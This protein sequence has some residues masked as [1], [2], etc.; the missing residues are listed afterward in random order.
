MS[1]YSLD[2]I[3]RQKAKIGN[4]NTSSTGKDDLVL[5]NVHTNIMMM[6]NSN[7]NVDNTTQPLL[8]YSDAELKKILDE[9]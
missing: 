7:S 9:I 8:Y 5:S 2:L 1:K 6:G 3:R 4:N